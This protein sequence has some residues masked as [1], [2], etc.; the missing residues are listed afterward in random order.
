MITGV[1]YCSAC[2]GQRSAIMYTAEPTMS[3]TMTG[4][5][6]IAIRSSLVNRSTGYPPRMEALILILLVAG[7]ICFALGAFGV[8]ARVNWTPL[9]L[10][11][12][13]LTAIIGA[14][15]S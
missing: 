8:A 7:A 10:L 4:Q 6:L 2:A 12:W 11:F 1:T 5:H 13:I 9:G 15:P 3:A 14:I